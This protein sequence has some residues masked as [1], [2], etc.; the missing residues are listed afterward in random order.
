M[1]RMKQILLVEDDANL[2]FVVKDNLLQRGYEIVH[3]MDGEA[4][5]TAY[6]QRKF[7]LCLLDV[8][9][10]KLDGFNLAR[11]MR[12]E[13]RDIPILFLTAKSM[14]E[15][16]L[17]AFELGGDDFLTKPFSMDELVMR[18]EVFLRRSMVRAESTSQSYRLGT[19]TFLP[20][21]L[22]LQTNGGKQGLTQR[23]A[24]L[25]LFFCANK[26]QVL[27]RESILKAI[28]GDDDYFFGRSL[29]VF[30][31][32]L[33]KYLKQEPTIKIVNYHGV[34]FKFEVTEA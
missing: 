5:W 11:R 13:D 22:C 12:E 28:W 27:K 16:R 9:M 20:A 1:E 21:E 32:K 6:S 24:D 18:M 14:L 25:L 15:D 33:R 7:D 19:T 29:D 17:E 10:P 2:G 34:G 30:I 8:M 23:E 31:S 4:G 26:N 3:V